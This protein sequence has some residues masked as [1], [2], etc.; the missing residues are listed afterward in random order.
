MRT[1]RVLALSLLVGL[2]TV[3]AA[4]SLT[5]YVGRGE[6]LAGPIL[7]RFTADTGIQVE[8]RYGSTAELAV[9]ITE[10]GA[11][12]PAD[13]FWAQDA[14]ALGALEKAGLL[15]SVPGSL[16]ANVAYKNVHPSLNWV[17]VSARNR[18]LA[19]STERVSEGELPASAFDLVDPVYQNRV[20]WAPGNAS[21]QSFV[22]ALRM[23]YGEDVAKSWLEGMIANGARRYSNNG[24][25]LDGIASG[26]VDFALVNNYYLMQ[27]FASDPSFPAAQTFYA[28]GD[29]GNLANVT[30]IGVLASSGS[31]ELMH[32]LIAYLLSDEAQTYFTNEV[33]EYPITTTVAPYAGLESSAVVTAASPVVDL[34][35]IDDLEG[36]LELLREVGLL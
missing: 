30:G 18:V 27:R 35:S 5:L 36:T 13:G 1:L 7:E 20:A 11:A 31:Q 3:A 22:T 24:G 9:L 26:E 14:G 10:E 2:A 17:A 21:F 29:I 34:A 23:E 28:D 25:Q 19:Y 12:S 16:V 6:A 4:Q 33:Y 15:A 8:V 32:Q